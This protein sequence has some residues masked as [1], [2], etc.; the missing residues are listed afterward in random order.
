MK[1]FD[2]RFGVVLG[3]A[4]VVVAAA[5]M[6]G[7]SAQSMPGGSGGGAPKGPA[8]QEQGPR[9]IYIVGYTEP[10]LANYQG[11]QAG[12]ARPTRKASGRLDVASAAARAY[13]ADLGQ[14]QARHEADAARMLGRPMA[15]R[16]RMRHALNAVVT[17]L[18]ADEAAAVATMSEVAFVEP[19]REYELDTDRGP[20]HIGAGTVWNSG[21]GLPPGQTLPGTPHLAGARGEGIVFGIVDSGINF[22]SPSF[23]ATASDG[24]QHVNPL[25]SG[26]YLGTCAPGGVDEGRCN[27][28]LIGGYDFVCDAPGNR[29]GVAGIREEPGFGDTNGHGSHVASTA[30]GNPRTVDFRGAQVGISGVAP[31]GNIIAYDVCYTNISDGRGLCPNV[32]SAAAIDQAVADGVDVINFSIGGGS[33]P[34]SEAVSQAFLGAADAGVFVAASA[35]NSGPGAG[36]LGHHEP[37]VTTVAAAT[38][39]RQGYEFLLSLTGPGV[40]PAPLQSVVLTPGSNGVAHTMAIPGTTPFVVAPDFD[41]GSD[42]CAAYPGGTFQGAI[43]F[44]RRGGCSFS[45]KT[46]NATA[47]GAIAVVIANNAAGGLIPSV[48]GTTIP[49][50]AITQADG[51]AVRDFASGASATAGIG[52]PA[53]PV[54]NTPDVLGGFSSR[55]PANY[56]LVKPDVTAPGVAVLAADAGDTLEGFEDLVGLKNGTSMAS[57]HVAGAAGLLKQLNPSWTPAEIKS[58]LMMTATPEV[59]IEDG[60]TPADPFAMGAGRVQVRNAARAGLVMDETTENYLAANP[61]DGGDVS[62]LNLPG[63][64]EQACVGICTFTRTF[65][66]VRRPNVL[67]T[68]RV[69]GLKGFVWPALFRVKG[70]EQVKLTIVV[71]GHKLPA[72]GSWNFGKVVL[73]PVGHSPHVAD[74][75]LPMAI[76]VPPPKI[77]LAPSPV[78]VSLKAGSQGWTRASVDNDGGGW[79]EWSYQSS[80]AVSNVVHA[81]SSEGVTTGTLSAFMT[82][83]GSGFYAADDF[84]MEEGGTVDFLAARG[85]TVSGADLLATA[86]SITWSIYADDGGQP[87]GYPRLAPETALWTYTALPGSPGMGLSDGWLQLDPTLAGQDVQLP[88]GTYWLHVHAD[89]NIANRWAWYQSLQG[90]GSQAKVVQS[91]ELGGVWTDTSAT[92]PGLTFQ[93]NAVAQC[94]AAWLGAVVPGSGRIWGGQSRPLWLNVNAGGL[95][96]GTYAARACFASNDPGQ[97][98]ASVPVR[99]TVTP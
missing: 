94:G 3:T 2:S 45:I 59:L 7:V 6:S 4:L 21:S 8:A 23:S 65:R 44:V 11:D 39:G 37:W 58:A 38:H 64:N 53:T 54:A 72:D 95:A 16:K 67:W 99:L 17:E 82:D 1:Y 48:P 30:A 79:L 20:T 32:S 25:G 47:A 42:G 9:E 73:E 80:G 98:V 68:A 97:P 92:N 22:G 69:E 87:A 55:G 31:R 14:Q 19:Y 62:E 33:S 51:D 77:A 96:P 86:N 76:S 91:P 36:T 28:K 10:A 89:T 26:N 46:N 85:F 56:E 81:S 71:D 75:H 27:D 90:V 43:A 40:P 70:G 12:L 15:I 49:A 29:C 50:F 88:P 34:W 78:E 24:Y 60:A 52:Y 57:P 35:G 63:L 18:T 74:L 66:S 41:S 5:G 13:V 83:Y 93:V 61:V 84:V